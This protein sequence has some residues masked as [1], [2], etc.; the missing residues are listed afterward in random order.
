MVCV[1]KAFETQ[2][3][4]V[5]RRAFDTE[6][7]DLAIE[8]IPR[9]RNLDFLRFSIDVRIFS[10]LGTEHPENIII[11]G[12]PMILIVRTFVWKALA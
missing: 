10:G 6:S 3:F 8:T 2:Q 9:P 12:I 4:E 5:S 1:K 11:P 7:K